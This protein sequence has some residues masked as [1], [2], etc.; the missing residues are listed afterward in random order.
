MG[1]GGAHRGWGPL[2]ALFS[3][4]DVAELDA[5]SRAVCTKG[6][7]VAAVMKTGTSS[8]FID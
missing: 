8:S 7:A 6:A 2:C 5:V 1:R 3:W 4:G